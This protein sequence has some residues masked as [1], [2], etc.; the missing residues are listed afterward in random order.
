MLYVGER[1]GYKNFQFFLSA[2]AP[3]I[4]TEQLYLLCVG[5]RP[6]AGDEKALMNRLGVR[7]SVHHI[8]VTTAGELASLYH[9]ASALC[10]PSLHEGF[11]IPLLEAFACG[12]P[13]V[14]STIASSQEVAADAAEY[15]DPKDPS[16]ARSSVERVVLDPKRCEEL[17]RRGRERLKLFSWERAAKATLEVYKAAV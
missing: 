14:A 9:F 4:R 15:F 8:S 13:V 10:Y 12:C 11:G 5:S 7:G 2:A 16:S 17:V 3:V 6:F 1:G